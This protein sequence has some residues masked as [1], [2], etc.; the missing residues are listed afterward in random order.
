MSELVR[1]P[2]Q[3]GVALRR[4]RRAQ[5]MT[6]A[7]LAS[8]AGV[9]QGT[10]SHVENGLETVKLTTVMDLLRALDLE[11]VVRQRTKGSHSDIEDLF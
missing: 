5:A 2:K 4:S 9:R 1:S 6:Q 3:L 11:I 7:D 10:I 8:R